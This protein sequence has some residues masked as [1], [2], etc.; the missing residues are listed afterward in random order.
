MQIQIEEEEQQQQQ[1]EQEQ[2]EQQ[3]H[4]PGISCWD[5]ANICMGRRDDLGDAALGCKMEG[6]QHGGISGKYHWNILRV[7]VFQHEL[8]WFALSRCF[9]MLPHP[10]KN[11]QWKF[12]NWTI[13]LISTDDLS[14]FGKT[15]RHGEGR[16]EHTRCKP[17]NLLIFSSGKSG[18]CPISPSM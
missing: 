10:V 12:N 16:L 8:F 5:V 9:E 18:T 1:Q 7:R 4:T 13:A 6:F 3:Q 17:E 11:V 2:Q 14:S 15:K